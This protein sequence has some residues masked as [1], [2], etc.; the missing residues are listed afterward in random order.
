MGYTHYFSNSES[1]PEAWATFTDE[2]RAILRRPEVRALV[3]FES[4]EPGRLPEVSGEV[5]Q[6]NGR[7]EE[8][9]ETFLLPRAAHSGACKTGFSVTHGKSYDLAVCAVLIAAHQHLGEEVSSNGDWDGPGWL[10]ARQLYGRVT[11][12]IASCPWP[13]KA[14]AKCRRRFER[15]GHNWGGSERCAKCGGGSFGNR[16]WLRTSSIP[17]I[18]KI[19]NLSRGRPDDMVCMD[20]GG[21]KK[22]R[23]ASTSLCYFCSSGF[24]DNED[25]MRQISKVFEE[26]A[27]RFKGRRRPLHDADEDE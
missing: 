5:V 11:G 16:D 6:F 4:D 24:K 19:P 25:A 13:T 7:G 9:H 23:E 8:G 26:V 22:K 12:R 14:C 27:K 15:V 1:S 21:T 3:C 17:G 18:K 10:A 20:C 2:A